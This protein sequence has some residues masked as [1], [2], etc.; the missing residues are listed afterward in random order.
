MRQLP[1]DLQKALNAI[2][3]VHPDLKAL[4]ENGDAKS[5]DARYTEMVRNF[6]PSEIQR[7]GPLSADPQVALRQI[8]YRIIRFHEEGILETADGRTVV[9]SAKG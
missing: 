3:D 7:D 8:I 6:D 2:P 4:I 1:D 5:L 9:V